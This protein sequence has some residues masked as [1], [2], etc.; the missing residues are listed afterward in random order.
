MKCNNTTSYGIKYTVWPFQNGS[1]HMDYSINY[2]AMN[3][4]YQCL[5]VC[6]CALRKGTK[7]YFVARQKLMGLECFWCVGRLWTCPK[8][9]WICCE[10]AILPN[11]NCFK[12]QPRKNVT[13][14]INRFITNFQLHY[15]LI[16]WFLVKFRTTFKVRRKRLFEYILQSSAL[17]P[18]V[19]GND[20]I[21]RFFLKL[22]NLTWLE[23]KRRQKNLMRE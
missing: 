15:C 11:T 6:P 5:F 1:V 2:V 16:P 10:R 14:E 17:A 18:P 22:F 8:I 3:W 4:K 19:L 23:S 13:L 7:E 20:K 12:I 9:C 21:I